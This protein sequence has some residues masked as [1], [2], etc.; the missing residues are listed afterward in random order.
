MKLSNGVLALVAATAVTGCAASAAAPLAHKPTAQVPVAVV[1][2][3]EPE[4]QPEQTPETPDE[5]LWM[6]A[7]GR[8]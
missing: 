2:N 4:A 1:T 5:D 3:P 7:C 8:G 6:A